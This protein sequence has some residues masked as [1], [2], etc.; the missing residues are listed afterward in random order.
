MAAGAEPMVFAYMIGIG[1]TIGFGVWA[2][3]NLINEAGSVVAM[4]VATLRK[5]VTM[6]LSY[7]V[8]P[9][10]FTSIHSVA[11]V[12]VLMG[13][14]LSDFF[15]DKEERCRALLKDDTQKSRSKRC[16]PAAYA[17]CWR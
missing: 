17:N 5:V 6:L 13:I 15:Q 8:F 10:P 11:A 4:T 16:R 1:V 12:L 2:N 9:K 3:T 14:L 7:I